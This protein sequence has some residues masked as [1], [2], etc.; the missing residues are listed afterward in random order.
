MREGG[1]ERKRWWGRS[2][3]WNRGSNNGSVGKGTGGVGMAEG[4]RG[5]L[6]GNEFGGSG[7]P[8]AESWFVGKKVS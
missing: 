6:G 4:R 7:W 8:F 1:D 3:D 5:W 2:R